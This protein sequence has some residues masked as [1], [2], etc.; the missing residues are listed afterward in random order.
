MAPAAKFLKEL[1]LWIII[2]SDSRW[3]GQAL[4][5]PDSGQSGHLFQGLSSSIR[6]GVRHYKTDSCCPDILHIR[7]SLRILHDTRQILDRPI[8]LENLQHQTQHAL[9]SICDQHI[10]DY[11]VSCPIHLH[12]DGMQAHQ[13]LLGLAFPARLM[14][15]WQPCQRLFAQWCQS[16]PRPRYISGTYSS[17]VGTQAIISE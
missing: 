16:C 8:L 6:N 15:C 14:Q 17:I 4:R 2:S 5:Y 12:L 3:I 9:H 13:S 11:V 1:A 7:I 10:L